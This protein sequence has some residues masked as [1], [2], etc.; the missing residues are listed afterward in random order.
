MAPRFQDYEHLLRLAAVFAAGIAVFFVLQAVL[1]PKDFGELGHYRTS[2]VADNRARIPVYAGDAACA[3]CHEEVREARVQGAHAGVRCESCHG[4]QAMHVL[5]EGP[6]RR[7]E[8][9]FCI[10]CH[11]ANRARP[12]AF[13][14][15]NPAEHSGGETC[16]TCHPAHAPGLS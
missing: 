11:G 9:G 8:P 12:P 14:Q 5:G 15:V 6:A 3:D 13:P 7:P 2:A 4:P 10:R 16:T 1:V